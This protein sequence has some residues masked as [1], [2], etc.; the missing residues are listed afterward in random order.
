MTELDPRP[1]RDDFTSTECAKILGGTLG[2][3][4]QMASIEALTEAVAYWASPAGQKKIDELYGIDPATR[5]LEEALRAQG[6][7][8]R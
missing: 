7:L 4:S 1:P 2:A 8:A 5:E 3:L 6:A